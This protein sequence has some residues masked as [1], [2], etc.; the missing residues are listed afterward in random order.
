MSSSSPFASFTET[1]HFTFTILASSHESKSTSQTQFQP[2]G[3]EA[4]KGDWGIMGNKVMVNGLRLK[5][6][7]I[8]W[9][10]AFIILIQGIVHAKLVHR[11]NFSDIDKKLKQ[12]NR[13]AVKTIQMEPSYYPA[14]ETME[15]KKPEIQRAIEA[16]QLWRKSGSCPEGTIPI[17]RIRKEDLL[18]ASSLEDFGRKKPSFY[19]LSPEINQTGCVN[20]TTKSYSKQANLS[21]GTLLTQ[22]SAYLGAQGDIN[23]WN[24]YVAADNEYSGA[25]ISLKNGPY[26]DFESVE[27]GWVVNPSVY[28]DRRT[29]LFG[30]WTADASKKT[31]CFDLVCPGFVQTSQSMVLGA[32]LDPVSVFGGAQYQISTHIYLDPKTGNWWLQFGNLNLGYWPKSLFGALS[33][34]ASS[35]EW[36][37]EVSSSHIGQT[38]PH[39]A[40]DMGTGKY[41]GIGFKYDCFIR[42]LRYMDNSLN[43]KFPTVAYPYTDEYNCYDIYYLRDYI[44]E[45]EFYFGG[46]EPQKLLDIPVYFAKEERKRDWGIMRNKVM[47]RGL[48]LKEIKILWG[49]AFI[50]FVQGIVHAKLVHT[51]NNFSEIDKKL[52]QINRPAVKSIQMKPSYYP[53]FETMDKKKPELHRAIEA[54][55]LWRKSGSCPEGTIPIRRIRKQDLLRATS[56]GD[57]GRKKPS[58]SSISPEINQTGRVNFTTKSYNKQANLSVG[59]LITQGLA[60]LGAQGDI[61]VWNPY[62]AA[63]D[64]Y[65]AAYISLKNGP[66]YDFESVESGWVVNPSVY[67][68]RRTRIFGY[69]TA[70]AS[71][72]TGCFDLVCPGFVQTSQSIVLGGVL[73]HVSVFGGAQYQISTHFYLD[74]NTGNWWLQFGNLNLGYWPKSLFGSLSQMASSVEW[75]G[76]VSSSH[77]G[78]TH[79]HTATDMGTGEDPGIGFKYDCFIRQLRFIDNSL[80]L[81]FPTVAYPY[82]DEYNCYDIYYL[83]EYIDEPEFYFGGPGYDEVR[84][85]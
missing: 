14:F 43:L 46:P 81:K 55:Q 50:I 76:E 41:P 26:Y 42:G 10:I 64:E 17:R 1:S 25:Y 15:N 3:K 74:P 22:G 63:D 24:P 9:G 51:E 6:I 67:G 52:K 18:R 21:V 8:L 12:I 82:T 4:R 34:M 60:Y 65:S 49:I 27:S 31:G 7:K 48:R 53:A 71:K 56:L 68:D 11:E 23:V 40:T 33:Q 2:R 36:G 69:W 57:F 20:S 29:R 35:V 62:V 83:K 19:S 38:H 84:C 39:T 44:D 13:P 59:I 45:P 16:S 78:Q 5:E 37:G 58:F 80:Q 77:I 85:P 73:D 75:G 30:Y 79:P 28:G 72:K 32:V 61:N 54:S 47:A 70:D 66:Y